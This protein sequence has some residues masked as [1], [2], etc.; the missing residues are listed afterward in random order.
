MCGAVVAAL[1]YFCRGGRLQ[2]NEA[3]VRSGRGKHNALG[4]QLFQSGPFKGYTAADNGWKGSHGMTLTFHPQ[5]GHVVHGKGRDHV[6]VFVASGVYSPRTFRMAFDKIYQGDSTKEGRGTVQVEWNTE[7][8]NFQGKSYSTAG[9]RRQAQPY[10]LERASG[11]A[12]QYL[13]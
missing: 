2:S 5:A 8:R 3:Y 10:S 9:G 1:I 7:R 13:T 12:Q 11:H 6:G 4:E